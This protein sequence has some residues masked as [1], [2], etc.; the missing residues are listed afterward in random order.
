M[1]QNVIQKDKVGSIKD[2][3]LE[4]ERLTCDKSE[5]QNK[6][7][8]EKDSIEEMSEIFPEERKNMGLQMV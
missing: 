3:R 4:W 7:I 5:F 1:T 8:K 2:T 6:K